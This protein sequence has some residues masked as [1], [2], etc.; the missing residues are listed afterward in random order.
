M[1]D[2]FLLLSIC[3]TSFIFV[4]VVVLLLLLL[5]LLDWF[6]VLCF[7]SST[8]SPHSFIHSIS[9]HSTHSTTVVSQHQQPHTTTIHLF[10]H[11]LLLLHQ[12]LA[13]A[14]IFF[15]SEIIAKRLARFVCE[16][17]RPF[18]RQLASQ[19]IHSTNPMVSQSVSWWSGWSVG[20]GGGEKQFDKQAESVDDGGD[21]EFCE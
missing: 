14:F 6:V 8:S 11:F 5:C 18:I 4:V 10:Q 2:I 17:L 21:G 16:K 15:S 19:Q 9:I 3:S 7:S 12:L 13:A 1:E 20:G